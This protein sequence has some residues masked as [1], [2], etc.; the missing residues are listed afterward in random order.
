MWDLFRSIDKIRDGIKNELNSMSSIH[1]RDESSYRELWFSFVLRDYV[2]DL[3]D[4]DG[5]SNLISQQLISLD[6]I[7]VS[8]SQNFGK[9]KSSYASVPKQHVDILI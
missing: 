1:F 8:L 9:I 3:P 6:K 7:L 5:H 2:K 4:D